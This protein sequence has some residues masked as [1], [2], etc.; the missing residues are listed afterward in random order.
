MLGREGRDRKMEATI[1]FTVG[2]YR[3]TALSPKPQTCRTTK[4]IYSFIQITIT[5]LIIVVM[6]RI[7]FIATIAIKL[8]MRIVLPKP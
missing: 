3:E 8:M 7:M 1:L 2:G 5:V 4:R 6:M